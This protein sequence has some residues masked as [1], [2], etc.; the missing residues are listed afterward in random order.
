MQAPDADPLSINGKVFY[1]GKETW[2]ARIRN[3]KKTTAVNLNA[4]EHGTQ[5]C[6]IEFHSVES[7]K[8]RRLTVSFS[9][10]RLKEDQNNKYRTFIYDRIG[11]WL[12]TEGTEGAL[13]N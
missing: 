13:G 9:A 3:V 5:S 6:T 11:R 1:V 7:E 2:S 8:A 10:Q 4:L 12:A